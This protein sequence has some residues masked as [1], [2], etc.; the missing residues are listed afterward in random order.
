MFNSSPSTML[1]QEASLSLSL[2]HFPYKLFRGLAF[3]D[4]PL[5]WPLPYASP[6]LLLSPTQ[7][8]APKRRPREKKS[9]HLF[10]KVSTVPWKEAAS[11]SH[12]STD[13]KLRNLSLE[14]I[15]KGS[16]PLPPSTNG[17]DDTG[18]GYSASRKTP[19]FTRTDFYRKREKFIVWK[20]FW[21][22]FFSGWLIIITRGGEGS[23]Y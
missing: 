6:S 23:C 14:R 2:S 7:R 1:P 15:S 3:K 4:S 20:I 11:L 12:R 16:I 18:G 5:C 8:N 21:K 17:W 13:E 9:T 10:C 22:F 19:F